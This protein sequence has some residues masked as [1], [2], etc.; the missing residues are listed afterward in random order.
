MKVRIEV[1][2]TLES[3]GRN[4]NYHLE[5]PECDDVFQLLKLYTEAAH[6]MSYDYIRQFKAECKDKSIIHLDMWVDD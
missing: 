4:Y 5:D 6:L 2:E 1:E 3:D